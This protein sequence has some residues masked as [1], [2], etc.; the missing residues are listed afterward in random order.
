MGGMNF[1]VAKNKIIINNRVEPFYM[2]YDE[3]AGKGETLVMVHGLMGDIS[4][5]EPLIPYLAS[6]Y[7]IIIPSLPFFESFDINDFNDLYIV[8]EEFMEKVVRDRVILIGNSLGGQ[9]SCVYACHNPHRVKALVITGSSGLYENSFGINY[10][11]IRDYDFVRERVEFTFYDRRVATDELVKKCYDMVND[12]FKRRKLIKI[13]RCSMRYDISSVLK[14]MKVP[15]CIIWGKNDRITPPDVAR[16]FNSM[17]KN[18]FIVWIDKCG[19][20]PMMEHP[21]I[22]SKIIKK[23]IGSPNFTLEKS[24]YE[25]KEF[26]EVSV[27]I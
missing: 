23:W 6:D 25:W 1:R 11:R 21:D 9:L 14:N 5:F 17:V 3:V 27:G 22:F 4:N 7:H 18:S 10:P 19:H 13:S 16:K 12:K 15:V 8:F 2:Y 24:E 20:V 26:C